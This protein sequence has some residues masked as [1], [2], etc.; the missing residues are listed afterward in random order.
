MTDVRRP[1]FT[2]DIFIR[3]KNLP[4]LFRLDVRYAAVF[5]LAYHRDDGIVV[6][7]FVSAQYQIS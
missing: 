7:R 5:L 4:I 1:S 3:L 2:V 6:K